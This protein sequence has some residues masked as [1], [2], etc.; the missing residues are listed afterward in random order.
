[1][2]NNGHF[3][4]LSK[5]KIK[6]RCVICSSGFMT[7]YTAKDSM[8]YQCLIFNGPAAGFI[9]LLHYLSP[10]TFTTAAILHWLD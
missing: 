8:L 3:F 10:R 6:L 2:L 7:T 1:M 4:L 9:I 5:G